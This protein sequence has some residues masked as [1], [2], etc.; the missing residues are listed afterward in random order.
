MLYR[1]LAMK[2]CAP[3]TVQ[4]QTWPERPTGREFEQLWHF[5]SAS[6]EVLGKGHTV[7]SPNVRLQA[8]LTPSMCGWP[9]A[10]LKRHRYIGLTSAC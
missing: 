4:L 10:K 7:R 9:E 5:G 2:G 3:A 6:P 1:I 8:E